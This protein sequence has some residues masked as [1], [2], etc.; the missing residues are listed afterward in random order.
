MTPKLH[1]TLEVLLVLGVVA[2]ATAGAQECPRL[3]GRWPYGPTEVVAAGDDGT[4]YIGSGSAFRAVDVTD[5]QSPTVIG[6]LV[7]DDTD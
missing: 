2:V 5:P 4:V 3:V 1:A 6:E 7:V